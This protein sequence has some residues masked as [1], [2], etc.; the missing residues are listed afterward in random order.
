M[1]SR[2]GAAFAVAVTW[3]GGLA[4]LALLCRFE[5]VH[6]VGQVRAAARGR[7][8]RQIDAIADRGGHQRMPRQRHGLEPLPAVGRRVEGLDLVV[9]AVRRRLVTFAAEDVELAIEH[10]GMPARAAGRHW[11]LLAPGSGRGIEFLDRG[12]VV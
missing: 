10:R 9:E 6:I 11:G 7:A 8:A 12:D 4:A 2:A 5:S 1:T 3:P